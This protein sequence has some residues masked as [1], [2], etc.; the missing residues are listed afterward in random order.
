MAAQVDMNPAAKGQGF[1]AGAGGE[2]SSECGDIHRDPAV[3]KVVED[4]EG[5]VQL[6]E[7]CQALDVLA[8]RVGILGMEWER[9]GEGVSLPELGNP[10]RLDGET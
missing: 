5:L 9:V 10:G 7:A 1:M 8:N 6:T 4:G 2:E 3:L